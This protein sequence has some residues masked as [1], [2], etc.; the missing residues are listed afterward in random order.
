MRCKFALSKTSVEGD[1]TELARLQD[2]AQWAEARVALERADARL[3]GGGPSGLR[4]RLDQA[5]HDLDLVVL[6]DD[7]HLNRVGSVEEEGLNN[8]PAHADLD[9][10]A[11]FRDA[12]LGKVQDDPAGVATR[13]RGS[14]VR[15]ALVAALDD[16]AVSV[17]DQVRRRWLL[18]VAR[19]A[20]PDPEGWRDRAR[21][22]RAW[23]DGRALAELADMAPVAGRSVQLLLALGE[24]WRATGADATGFLRRVQ[25]EHPADFWANF[26]LANALKYRNAGEAISYFR[27]AL[28]IRPRAAIASY[29]LGES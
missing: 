26:T 27:V 22:P 3:D 12:G 23:E 4:R 24:R 13:V 28:A 11:A 16:W 25:R 18:E 9:Y 15:E 2:K 29:N 5:R 7:I 21:D 8:P 17:T 6:L 10:E 19:R 20:D 1:L 14:A